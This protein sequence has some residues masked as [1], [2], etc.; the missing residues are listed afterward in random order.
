MT[1]TS[2]LNINSITNPER[3]LSEE[4]KARAQAELD[5]FTKMSDLELK[6]FQQNIDERKH[7]ASCL[8]QLVG[9][10]LF[11]VGIMVFGYGWQNGPFKPSESVMLAILGGTTV[12]VL[13]LFVIV[14]K[15][16]FPA[17]RDKSK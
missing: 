10:W 8:F 7:Y 11:V 15:Y 17:N 3:L 13:G 12:N 9:I 6:S 4:A 14:T 16:L 2:R 1:T 5:Y